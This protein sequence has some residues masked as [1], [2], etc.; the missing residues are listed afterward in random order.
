[1]SLGEMLRSAVPDR[2]ARVDKNWASTVHPS[3]L[4]SHKHSELQSAKRL[5]ISVTPEYVEQNGSLEARWLH[6][7]ESI[8]HLSLESKQSV[9]VCLPDF[10]DIQR[11]KTLFENLGLG[12]F[13]NVYDVQAT[14][15][16]QFARHLTALE[17]KPQIVVGSRSALYAPLSNLGCIVLWDEGDEA[18]QDEGSPYLHNRDVALVRQSLEQ[19]QLV[20]MQHAKSAAVKRL[21][22]IGYV[23]PFVAGA[24]RPSLSFSS[25]GFRVDSL[26]HRTIKDALN[27]GPVLIQVAGKGASASISCADCGKRASCTFCNGP[28][29][30]IHQSQIVCRLCSGFN[31]EA[32]CQGCGSKKIRRGRAGSTRTL[33]EFGKS[34]PGVRLIESTGA[35]ELAVIKSERAIV[36]CT[37]GAE[38]IC[39]TGYSAVVI[40]DAELELS[41]DRLDAIEQAIRKWSNAFS[42]LNQNGKGAIIGITGDL[43][44]KM[45]LW[46][47]DELIGKL[48]NE[49]MELGFPPAVRL[50][51]VSGTRDDLVSVKSALEGVSGVRVLGISAVD[52]SPDSRLIAT[53]QYSSG[54]EVARVLRTA[55]LSPTLQKRFTKNGR[56]QRPLTVKMDDSRVL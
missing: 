42:L 8:C 56:L 28:L 25:D 41:R 35:D 40:L 52:G 22:N 37:A 49:R 15:S 2:M 13:L 54:A 55:A 30:E 44:Q 21:E 3:E 53:Y 26:A 10:K 51:S 50:L 48:L 11:M 46:Q 16:E 9:I 36:V 14:K 39:E 33:Q 27:S 19:C 5:S 18:H 24:R 29:W 32:R 4:P 38:P 7:I 6:E 43:G 45:S 47:I 1:L 23:E 17:S 31:L 34:F 12:G 20:F